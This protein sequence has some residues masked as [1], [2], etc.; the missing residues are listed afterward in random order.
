MHKLLRSKLILGSKSNSWNTWIFLLRW[1]QWDAF[2]GWRIKEYNY[3]VSQNAALGVARYVRYN[4]FS[5]IFKDDSRMKHFTAALKEKKLLYNFFK[6]FSL[7]K[8]FNI[9]IKYYF[10]IKFIVLTVTCKDWSRMRLDGTWRN[11]STYLCVAG[12]I[13]FLLF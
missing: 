12:L 2:S 10:K 4:L 1:S 13:Q 9:M 7:W 11:L 8:K 6:R 5:I 3:F